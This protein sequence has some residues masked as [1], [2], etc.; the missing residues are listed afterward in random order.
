MVEQNTKPVQEPSYAKA[1]LIT[2]RQLMPAGIDT[3]QD[4]ADAEAMPLDKTFKTELIE[5]VVMVKKLDT[6]AQIDYTEIE[7][8]MPDSNLF[9]QIM[10][11]AYADFIDPDITR[12]DAIKWSSVGTQTGVGVFSAVASQLE[13]VQLFRKVMRTKI[14]AGYMA[15]SFPRQTMLN[16]Y[17][18][19]LHAHKGTLAYRAPL[20]MRMLLRHHHE[21]FNEA[22]KCEVLK[23]DKFTVDHP[24]VRKRNTRI[25]TLIPNQEFLDQLRKFPPNY[26][27]GAGLCKRLYIRG[28]SR[29]NPEDPDA[30][31]VAKRPRFAKRAMERFLR[32]AHDEIVKRAEDEQEVSE[33]M[34]KATI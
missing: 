20:L 3:Q 7:W 23:S 34:D 9:E 14:Y 1:P 13:L 21:D 4:A 15:E 17:G 24:V 27:F 11:E 32:D 29:I 19:S 22:C 8:D 5:F 25:I 2:L 33:Q 16:D 30:K 12:M 18:L 10:N 6:T 31:K 28:G 26:P